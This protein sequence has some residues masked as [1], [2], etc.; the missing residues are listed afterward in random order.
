MVVE[1]LLKMLEAVLPEIE[2][3][4]AVPHDTHEFSLLS[5]KF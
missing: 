3:L 1:W 4:V 5:D 2:I